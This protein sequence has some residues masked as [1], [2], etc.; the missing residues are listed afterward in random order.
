[1]RR[2]SQGVLIGL[3]MLLL[4]VPQI[5]HAQ[6]SSADFERADQY[7]EAQ[8][9]RANIPG[10]A[11][12][13][14]G[15]E[16]ILHA[17]GFGVAGPGRPVTVDTPFVLGS[18]S[19]PITSLAIMQLVEA[20]RI[21][22][23]VPIQRYLPWF[24]V[25]PP[26][27]ARAIIVR[28]LL[29]QTSGFST[30]EGRAQLGR[31][32]ASDTAL[33]DRIRDLARARLVTAPGDRFEY[34]NINYLL[35]GAIIEAVSGQRYEPYIEQHVFAK[36]QMLQSFAS[37]ATARERGLAQG[38]HYWFGR[39]VPSQS[40]PPRF[41]TA[42]GFLVSSAADL[43]RL[44]RMYLN[45][46]TLDGVRMLVPESVT[47]LHRP[48]TSLRD[49]HY[50]LGWYVGEIEGRRIVDHDGIAPDY[51]AFLSLT[52]DEGWGFALL[53]NAQNHLSGPNIRALPFQ[54]RRLL[55]GRPPQP[56]RKGAGLFSPLLLGLCLL[57]IVQLVAGIHTVYVVRR[58]KQNPAR[59]PQSRRRLV[60]H[61]VLPLLA[62]M[63]LVLLLVVILPT[64]YDVSFFDVGIFAPDA[65]LVM[66]VSV[67][68]ACL[69]APVRTLLVLR[70]LRRGSVAPLAPQA[71]ARR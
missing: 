43:S 17:R 28:H 19:K 26:E 39:P 71:S 47:T 30:A 69:W 49:G 46:G 21:E 50:A 56:I 45:N 34:S 8:L 14:V 29:T 20:G 37:F 66:F 65:A 16:G 62:S 58:W 61:G 59:Q 10:A 63:G 67:A 15:R 9:Q 57:P 27:H 3:G 60:W 36:L 12:A 53:V 1:M 54:V 13:I 52:P 24:Q 2:R 23:D 35:A 18:V 40:A 42:A 33:E 6:P 55:M 22:L 51:S 31:R 64:R 38:H 5:C 41:A 11:I 70:T 4:H 68:L 25:V 44:L 7:V 48:A 32:D